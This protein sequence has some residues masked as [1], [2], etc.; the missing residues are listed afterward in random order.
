MP[1][2]EASSSSSSR[3]T[4]GTNLGKNATTNAKTSVTTTF[5]N[6]HIMLAP[7]TLMVLTLALSEITWL[8]LNNMSPFKQQKAVSIPLM[9]S[10]HVCT[11]AHRYIEETGLNQS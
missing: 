9:S 6:K 4:F 1:H 3:F 5:A 2:F 7:I 10:K 8:S 11:N